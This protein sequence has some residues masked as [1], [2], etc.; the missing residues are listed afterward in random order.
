MFLT[1]SVGDITGDIV[2]FASMKYER[3][4]LKTSKIP[5]E[6]SVKY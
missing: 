1:N 3:C 4:S 2:V 6:V 5:S